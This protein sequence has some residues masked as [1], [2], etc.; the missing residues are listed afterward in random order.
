MDS[1]CKTCGIPLW[2]SAIINRDMV[3]GTDQNGSP[4]L[5]AHEKHGWASQIIGHCPKC[6]AEVVEEVDCHWSE[7]P[8]APK[9]PLQPLPPAAPGSFPGT[10][11]IQATVKTG[12]TTTTAT[13]Q[14]PAPTTP[15][16][17]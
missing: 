7:L 11:A 1:T 2:H 13:V 16:A 14:A 9:A 4:A 6:H 10:A 5:V 17:K 15:E 8:P 3:Q 12:T